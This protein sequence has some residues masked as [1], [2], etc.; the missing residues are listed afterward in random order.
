MTETMDEGRD[1]W[2][3]GEMDEEDWCEDIAQSET[4]LLAPELSRHTSPSL[5]HFSDFSKQS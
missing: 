4:N 1:G 3:D 2:I 5:L